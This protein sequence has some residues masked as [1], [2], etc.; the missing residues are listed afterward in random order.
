MSQLHKAQTETKQYQHQ[1]QDLHQFVNDLMSEKEAVSITA[2]DQ[3]DELKKQVDRMKKE[4]KKK[5]E[6]LIKEQEAQRLSQ[7][8][9]FEARRLLE[10]KTQS[11]SYDASNLYAARIPHQT[12]WPIFWLRLSYSTMTRG[13]M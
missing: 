10:Q 1:V 8:E 13:P 3:I 5:E 6:Q 4:S 2:Q 9:L 11:E 12:A 7:K